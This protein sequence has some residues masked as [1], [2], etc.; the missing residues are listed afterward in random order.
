MTKPELTEFLRSKGYTL[1]KEITE[2]YYTDEIW[3]RLVYNT[4]KISVI[5]RNNLSGWINAT[6]FNGDGSERASHYINWL[7]IIDGEL[8][9]F[10]KIS[11]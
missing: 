5:I 10:Y 8:G 9:V 7:E 3:S 1:S 2:E 11:T 4:Y 6:F